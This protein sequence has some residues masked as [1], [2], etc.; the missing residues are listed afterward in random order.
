L[1]SVSGSA[2]SRLCTGAA[3]AKETSASRGRYFMV[4]MVVEGGLMVYVKKQIRSVEWFI[5]VS[6]FPSLH[7]LAT[8]DGHDTAV[9]KEY[10][11]HY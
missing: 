7:H 3:V 1:Y 2:P 8:A 4:V 5:H 10:V 6:P 11:M 9:T